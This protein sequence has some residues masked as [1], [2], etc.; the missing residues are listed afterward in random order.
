MVNKL[1]PAPRPR[2]MLS[3][4]SHDE[5]RMKRILDAEQGSS[6]AQINEN[7]RLA[8]SLLSYLYVL[9]LNAKPYLPDFRFGPSSVKMAAF[10]APPG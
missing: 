5:L 3:P 2:R 4:P 6:T 10:G 9:Q 1:A 7:L 8:S